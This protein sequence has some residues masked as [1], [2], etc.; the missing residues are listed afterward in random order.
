MDTKSQENVERYEYLASLKETEVEAIAQTLRGELRS[1][2]SKPLLKSALVS[3]V[4]FCC[5]R[6]GYIVCRLTSQLTTYLRCWTQIDWA[7]Y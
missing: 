7:C 5:W 3:L 6:N 1:E 2:G 4:F